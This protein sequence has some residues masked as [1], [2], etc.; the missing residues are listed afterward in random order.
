[1]SKIE[2]ALRKAE[3]ERRQKAH[4]KPSID[5]PA[6]AV[7]A[8]IVAPEEASFGAEESTSE[9]FRKITAKLKSYYDSVGPVDILFTSAVSGEGK[10]TSAIN[11][12]VSLCRDFNLSVCLVDCDL[13]KPGISSYFE[14]NG[15]SGI[16]DFLR[17]D[18]ELA[19][20]LQTTSIE[21]LSII[22]SI[23]AVKESLPLL[24][25]ERFRRL[26]SDLR[27]RFDFA[28]FDS[29]P[30]LPLTDTIIISRHIS[31][32]VLIVESGRTRRKHVEQVL[33]QI[34]G[35]KVIGFIMNHNKAKIPSSY[36]YSKYYSY[37]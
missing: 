15:N 21:N 1:M 36:N 13:H 30:I 2:R 27:E 22:R 31:A 4:A 24:N 18:A 19:S 20:V 9:H 26:V 32:M 37:E 25:S 28:I 16:A 8:D 3:E 14:S 17:G 34:D 12:A 33:E 11:C 6:V 5:E 35:T 7:P 23:G 10:T 29:S